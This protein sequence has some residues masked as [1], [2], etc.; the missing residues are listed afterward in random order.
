VA[1]KLVEIAKEVVINLEKVESKSSWATNTRGRAV[2]IKVPRI[3][4]GRALSD[5]LVMEYV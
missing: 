1:S 3:T 5:F 2:P 4:H